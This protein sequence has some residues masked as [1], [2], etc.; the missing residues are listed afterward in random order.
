MTS[1]SLF[2]LGLD[3]AVYVCKLKYIYLVFISG[4]KCLKILSF[5][6]FLLSVSTGSLLES[7]FAFFRF[8]LPV[9]FFFLVYHDSSL[10]HSFRDKKA[11]LLLLTLDKI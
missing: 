7:S 2:D 10:Q 3:R 5:W 8:I 4:K 11:T 6:L 1:D 9:F